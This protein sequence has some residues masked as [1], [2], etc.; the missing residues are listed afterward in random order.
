MVY[1]QYVKGIENILRT[2]AYRPSTAVGLHVAEDRDT[3]GSSAGKDEEDTASSLPYV[4]EVSTVMW[5]SAC[6]IQKR[7][8]LRVKNMTFP[9]N[10]L[11]IHRW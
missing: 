9:V 8:S 6:Y 4:V 2:G 7:K 10:L 1:N 3:R 5:L 11:V